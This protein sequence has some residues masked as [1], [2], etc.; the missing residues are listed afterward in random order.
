MRRC[1]ENK[2][3]R[4]LLVSFC[5]NYSI[6][7]VIQL[8]GLSSLRLL[9]NPFR[10]TTCL[11]LWRK[12]PAPQVTQQQRHPDTREMLVDVQLYLSFWASYFQDMSTDGQRDQVRN[13]MDLSETLDLQLYRTQVLVIVPKPFL[14][15]GIRGQLSRL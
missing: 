13:P 9:S 4:T 11:V 12:Q 3:P 10:P 6:V 14:L 8:E 5:I 7:W 15:L 1:W 2:T